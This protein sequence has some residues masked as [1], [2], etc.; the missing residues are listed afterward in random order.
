M[1]LRGRVETEALGSIDR[2]VPRVIALE[3][4]RRAGDPARGLGALPT[5]AMEADG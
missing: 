3:K 2:R 5:S 4:S 1:F